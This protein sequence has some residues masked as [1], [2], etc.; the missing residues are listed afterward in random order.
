MGGAYGRRVVVV[1]GKGNN[2][3]D[4]FVAARYLAHRGVLCRVVMMADPEALEGDALDAF[5]KMRSAG[6]AARPYDREL[7]DRE[8]DRA[9]LAVDAMLG[10]G[11]TGALRGPM[12]EAAALL[13]ASGVPVLAVDIPSGVDGETG[14]VPGEAVRA[15][16]TVTLAALKSGLLLPPGVHHTGDVEVVDIGIPRAMMEAHLQL[17]DP[18]DLGRALPPRTLTSNKRRAGRVLVLAGSAGM[19]GAAALTASGALRAGAG[20]VRAAVPE[21]VRAEVASQ[22]VESLSTGLAATAAGTF[23][24]EAVAAAVEL[25][26]QNQSVALGPGL[27]KEEETMSFVRG[28]LDRVEQP[29]VLDADGLT[30]FEGNPE[31]L[32]TRTAPTLLTP[33]AGELGRLLGC[34]PSQIEAD[35]P[36]AAREAAARSG[37]TVLLKGYR[38]LVAGPDGDAVMVDAGG[39]VLATGGTGDVLTGVIAALATRID[40]F[41]ATWA[42]ACLHGAAGDMLAEWMGDSGVVASDLLKALPLVQREAR[43]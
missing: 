16:R 39:P 3:G 2:G 21:P 4:G 25:A 42:G 19:A 28:V 11:F 6:L 22:V 33:H 12:A 34:P 38:T 8:L 30:A 18:G 7:L 36:A 10:T 1:C 23:S 13:N 43:K 17:A 9:D 15:A 27:S 29:V 40:P 14:A 31:G 32:K 20:L 26:K 35:R 24:V 41:T 37:A 5:G